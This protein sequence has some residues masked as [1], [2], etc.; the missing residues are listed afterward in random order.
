MSRSL[1]ADHYNGL[2]S[3]G[4]PENHPRVAV[5][6]P[7]SAPTVILIKDCGD[8]THWL[9][10]RGTSGELANEKPGGRRAI[11]AEVKRQTDGSWRVSRF[12]VKGLGSC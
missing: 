10:Y 2:V 6:D 11:T 7:P 9:K 1:Y 3:K 8:S 5:L 12:A 4:R